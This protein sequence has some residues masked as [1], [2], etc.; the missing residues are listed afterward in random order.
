[1]EPLLIIATPFLIWIGGNIVR[2]IYFSF[3]SSEKPTPYYSSLKEAKFDAVFVITT[4]SLFVAILYSH[5]RYNNFERDLYN[6]VRSKPVKVLN[7]PEGSARPIYQDITND[8]RFIDIPLKKTLLGWTTVILI[9]ILIAVFI[10]SL[11]W[12]DKNMY[13]L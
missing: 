9:I 8:D 13:R 11:N 6:S 4:L 2:G 7:S 12:Y 1:M 10:Y 5:D 3:I